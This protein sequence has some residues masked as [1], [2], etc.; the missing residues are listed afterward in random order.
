MAAS[1]V[2]QCWIVKVEAL[3]VKPTGS[4]GQT[5]AVNTLP[6]TV[7]WGRAAASGSSGIHGYGVRF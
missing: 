4:L 6:T 2:Q 5:M 3:Q 7:L 1:S